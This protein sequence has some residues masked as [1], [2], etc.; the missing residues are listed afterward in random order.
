[1]E[2]ELTWALLLRS[3]ANLYLSHSL[4]PHL[5]PDFKVEMFPISQELTWALL[6]QDVSSRCFG[7]TPSLR[8]TPELR[9]KADTETTACGCQMH[10]FGGLPLSAYSEALH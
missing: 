9:N 3:A 5:H 7:G 10:A 6:L 2:Q 1:M 4:Q 8:L